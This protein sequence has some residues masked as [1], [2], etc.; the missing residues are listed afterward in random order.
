[1]SQTYQRFFLLTISDYWCR[2]KQNAI[3]LETWEL[4]AHAAR[5]AEQAQ[6]RQY[7]R[8]RRSEYN[9]N[10][11]CLGLQQYDE[12]FPCFFRRS[13]DSTDEGTAKRLGASILT[14]NVPLSFSPATPG[15]ARHLG[16]Q[17]A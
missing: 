15:D 11:R 2:A 10:L 12:R 16:R 17:S 14:R 3:A 6:S 8:P 4:E 1:M 5:A 13:G 7:H 9:M